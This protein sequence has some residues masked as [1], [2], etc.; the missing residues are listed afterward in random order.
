MR[1]EHGNL[2]DR[3]GEEDINE[4]GLKMTVYSYQSSSKIR[5]L[6]E[7]GF[8]SQWVSYQSFR[9]GSLRHP[10][11][12]N[13]KFLTQ[14]KIAAVMIGK[15]HENSSGQKATVIAFR[16]FYDMDV[17]LESG[18]VVVGV[19]YEDFLGESKPGEQEVSEVI[20]TEESQPLFVTPCRD[21][22]SIGEESTTTDGN[23]MTIVTYRSA[24]D[25]TV[26][27]EDGTIAKHISYLNF[28]QGKVRARVR[29][30]RTRWYAARRIGEVSTTKQGEKMEIVAYFRWDNM[31]VR[32]EDGTTKEGV[33]YANFKR[34]EVRNPSKRKVFKNRKLLQ[35]A[36]SY[37]ASAKALLEDGEN[38]YLASIVLYKKSVQCFLRSIVESESDDIRY[39][40]Q[41]VQKKTGI[42]LDKRELAWLHDFGFCLDD[43]SLAPTAEDVTLAREVVEE[44]RKKIME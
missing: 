26:R 23:K 27:F 38:A 40:G 41:A 5:I 36:A 16:S 17:V 10:F 14:E 20:Q 37:F 29:N 35:K 22:I 31:T 44:I 39:L 34:G 3:T 43:D 7:D 13:G 21:G 28:K 32:F 4:Q 8:L 33:S 11:F 15:S 25:I 30:S 19:T 12:Q 1:K 9:N 24:D 18:T 2:K 42:V 6:F